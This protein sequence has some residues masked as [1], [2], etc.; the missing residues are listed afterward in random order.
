VKLAVVSGQSAVEGE[1]LVAA[2]KRHCLQSRSRIRQNSDGN[3]T[4][5]VASGKRFACFRIAAIGQYFRG[6]KKN[7]AR[8]HW[9]DAGKAG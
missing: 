4:P 6:K 2:V 5:Q 8:G 3:S 1:N 9:K 7:F